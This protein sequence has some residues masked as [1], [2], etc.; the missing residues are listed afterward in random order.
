M[1]TFLFQ[2]RTFATDR[3]DDDYSEVVED[4]AIDTFI[5]DI[6]DNIPFKSHKDENNG[7]INDTEDF[8]VSVLTSQ[9]RYT[10]QLKA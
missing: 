10:R 4:N 3:I 6:I 2:R 1:S 5:S 9:K 7:K 8:Y